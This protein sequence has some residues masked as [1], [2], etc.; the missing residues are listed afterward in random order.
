[1]SHGIADRASAYDSAW[2]RIKS[3]E[4][5][6]V[7]DDQSYGMFNYSQVPE[8]FSH[9][10]QTR[11]ALGLVGGNEVTN[12]S[13]SIVDLESD[14]FGIT[15]SLTKY[16]PRQYTPACP[17]GGAGCPDY[18]ADRTFVDRA[19]GKSH[20]IQTKPRDLPTSQFTAY[21]GVGRPVP[22]KQTVAYPTLF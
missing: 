18:P 10:K 13:G 11:N 12:I 21:P 8:K 2:N 1:M 16:A 5:A 22:L 3:T 20:T 7:R 4:G 6:L 19:T 14:L 9:P 17:L 15:R